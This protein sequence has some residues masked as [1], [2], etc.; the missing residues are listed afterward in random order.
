MSNSIALKALA[1]H[2][3][4]RLRKKPT[5]LYQGAPQSADA[6]TTSASENTN[7]TQALAQQQPSIVETYLERWSIAQFDGCQDP[8]RAKRIAYQ[9]SFISALNFLSYDESIIEGDEIW[10][11]ERIRLTLEWLEGLKLKNL[12][13]TE[14]GHNVRFSESSRRIVPLG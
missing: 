5:P 11:R 2:T 6:E 10:L 12:N 14:L 9:E 1:I 4:E 13:Y 3:L 8:N 7:L